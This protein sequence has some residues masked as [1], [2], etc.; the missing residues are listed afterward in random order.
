MTKKILSQERLEKEENWSEKETEAL[1]FKT[2]EELNHEETQADRPRER[3]TGLLSGARGLILGMVMGAVLAVGASKFLSRPGP[4]TDGPP[5]LAGNTVVAEA[6]AALTVTL[7]PVELASVERTM[8][9][10]YRW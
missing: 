6:K 4:G 8:D 5:E 9:A 10:T 2:L 7:A 1:D 3:P